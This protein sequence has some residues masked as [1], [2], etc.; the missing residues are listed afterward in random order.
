MRD[1]S[2]VRATNRPAPAGHGTG[3][4]AM[5]FLC[6]GGTAAAATLTVLSIPAHATVV[7]R[8]FVATAD[9]TDG[10]PVTAAGFTFGLTY[11]PSVNTFFN[12]PVDYYTTTSSYAS[13]NV[14]PVTF[15]RLGSS[16][17][18]DG[19]SFGLTSYSPDFE[20]SVLQNPP[21]TTPA[22][23]F[24]ARYSEGNGTPA[25][26]A[27]GDG[28]LTQ[29]METTSPAPEPAS[30]AMMIVGFGT[31]GGAMRVRQRKAALVTA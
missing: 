16:L 13:F 21:G 29:V 1:V 7:T 10:G 31:V 6:V 4:N 5:K 15:T 23:G 17:Y 27:P 3:D 30:W 18:I 9:F 22:L 24:S 2:L 20:L 11:D 12:M 28:V 25:H 14:S 26:N 19:V 8:T